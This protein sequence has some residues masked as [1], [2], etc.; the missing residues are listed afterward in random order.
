MAGSGVAHVTNEEKMKTKQVVRCDS[1]GDPIYFHENVKLVGSVK[2]RL[3]AY[4]DTDRNNLPKIEIH[5][6]YCYE[7][8]FD[9]GENQQLDK[10]TQSD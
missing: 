5:H 9:P 6:E 8:K 2:D 1:C 3:E 4:F 10:F 7:E